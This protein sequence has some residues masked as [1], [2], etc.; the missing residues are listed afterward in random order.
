MEKRV[1]T[2]ALDGLRGVAALHVMVG[3]FVHSGCP[4]LQMT[5]FYLLSG[6][7]LTLAYG[8]RSTWS[9]SDILMFYW[10]R[11]VRIAPSFYLSN[12]VAFLL[13][14]NLRTLLLRIPQVVTTLTISNSWFKPG[15]ESF[16]PFNGP[17]WTVSTLT[18]MYL[19]FPLMLPHLKKLSDTSLSRFLVILYYVQLL[20]VVYMSQ[21]EFTKER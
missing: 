7:T 19:A 9:Q 12:I 5:L 1:D 15:V 14:V 8:G 13:S 20:P 3:H 11:I 21:Y 17:S 6:Y 4:A 2:R 10:N 18:M 16:N